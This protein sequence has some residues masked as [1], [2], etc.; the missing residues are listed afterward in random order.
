MIEVESLEQAEAYVKQARV[1]MDN[2]R[3]QAAV[4]QAAELD[5]VPQVYRDR[6]ANILVG[7]SSVTK[8]ANLE[9]ISVQGRRNASTFLTRTANILDTLTPSAPVGA[10]ESGLNQVETDLVKL[11][12]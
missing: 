11:L 9:N 3:K 2:L 4:K 1:C 10:W 7:L 5:A 6:L 8:A 12:G